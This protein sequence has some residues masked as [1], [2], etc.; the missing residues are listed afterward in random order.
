MKNLSLANVLKNQDSVSASV[1][2][3]TFGFARF[4]AGFGF[5]VPVSEQS[6]K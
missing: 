3:F 6:R 1:F 4:T 2:G 5:Y